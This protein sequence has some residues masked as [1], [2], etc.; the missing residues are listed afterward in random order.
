MR[1]LMLVAGLL[2]AGCSSTNVSE[3][4]KA[5]A[6]DPNTAGVYV[7]VGTPWGTQKA[8]FCRS[9]PGAKVTCGDSGMT[10]EPLAK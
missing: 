4:V 8:R 9:A 5:L 1:S 7:D 2:L 6:A 3:L 10:V